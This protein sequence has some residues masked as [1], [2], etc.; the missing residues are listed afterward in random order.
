MGYRVEYDSVKK[1][2]G[3]QKRTAGRLAMTGVF[4][5]VF[6]VLVACFWPEGTAILRD[7][8][9]PGDRAVTAAALEELARQVSQGTDL[10]QA[11]AE[12][13]RDL[14]AGAGI[15]VD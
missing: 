14:L 10:S 8:L 13:C 2:R 12:F 5:L 11:V 7:A 15:G 3:V 4:F 1:V 9:L 6:L